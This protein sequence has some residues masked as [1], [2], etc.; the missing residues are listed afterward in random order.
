MH[1]S[2]N[3]ETESVQEYIPSESDVSV[4]DTRGAEKRDALKKEKWMRNIKIGADKTSDSDERGR[5]MVD[6]IANPS[7]YRERCRSESPPP[8]AKRTDKGINKGHPNVCSYCRPEISHRFANEADIRGY[9]R[10]LK[11]QEYRVD[12]VDE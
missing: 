9:M 2:D 3:V 5:K 8:K 1:T 11:V 6:D 12:D 10:E 4:K 7:N